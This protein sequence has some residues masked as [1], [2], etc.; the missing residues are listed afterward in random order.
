[1]TMNS[2]RAQL[3]GT[4][5]ITLAV[6]AAFW[7][8]EGAG[9]G[10]IAGAL[11]LAF[12]T[13]IYFGRER[14]DAINVMSGVGDERTRSLYTRTAAF[15]G[16]VVTYVVVLW[17]LVTLVQGHPNQTLTVIASIAGV[18]FIVGAILISRRG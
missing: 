5:A 9:Q 16:T 11:I 12:V 18:A 6:A 2:P 8:A 1:M 7:I 17:W 13:L 4:L 15:A 10:L 3:L 14:L